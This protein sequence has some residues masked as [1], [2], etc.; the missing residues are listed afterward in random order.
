MVLRSIYLE[1]ERP[2][3]EKTNLHQCCIA[4]NRNRQLQCDSTNCLPVPECQT[5][6]AEASL[7]QHAVVKKGHLAAAQEPLQS[8]PCDKAGGISV[9][10]QVSSREELGAPLYIK[11]LWRQFGAPKHWLSLSSTAIK[12]IFYSKLNIYDHWDGDRRLRSP[13]GWLFNSTFL[14]NH[15][16]AKERIFAFEAATV[17]SRT[18]SQRQYQSRLFYPPLQPFEI[19]VRSGY[20][21]QDGSILNV[22]R[23][24]AQQVYRDCLV[25]LLN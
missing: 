24:Q 11:S 15:L 7:T 16:V 10:R 23:A 9:P 13:L 6:L 25:Y 3:S 18:T 19:P 22:L 12:D 2:I 20:F 4:V 14:L 21:D 1:T 17:S 8:L 5:A